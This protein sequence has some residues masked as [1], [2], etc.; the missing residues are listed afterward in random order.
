MS[1]TRPPRGEPSGRLNLEQQR[2]RVKELLR[3]HRRGDAEAGARVRQR[4][5]RSTAALKLAEAQ[6]VVALEAGFASW[7]RLKLYAKQ[8]AQSRE[9]LLDSLLSAALAGEREAVDSAL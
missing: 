3:A 2:K 8:H 7:A 9:E 4:L 6:H 1:N 5:L